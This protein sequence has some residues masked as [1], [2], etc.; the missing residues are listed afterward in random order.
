MKVR[1]DNLKNILIQGKITIPIVCKWGHPFILLNYQE[2]SLAYCYLMET[3]L[4]QLHCRFGHL[5][6]RQ[7]AMVLE[8]SGYDIDRQVLEKLTEYCHQCQ[9]HSKAPG[10]YKFTLKDNHEFNYLIIVNILY[11]NGKPVLQ[12]IDSATAFRATR[13]LTDIKATTA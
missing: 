7:L 13:F 5:S 9:L 11:L 1:F 12:I 6:I 10:R 4:C 2:Q 8:Q 3:Q